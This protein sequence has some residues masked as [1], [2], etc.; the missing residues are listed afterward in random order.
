MSSA[1][2]TVPKYLRKISGYSF[3]RLV[4]AHEH[5]AELRELLLDRVVDDLGV[6]LGADAGEE[7]A[8][9]LGDAEPLERRLDLVGDV[10]PRLLLA[11]GRLAVVDDLVEVDPVEPVGPGRHRAL[12]EV[13]VRAEAVLEHPVRLVLEAADLLDR[14]ARQAALRLAQVDDVVV[15][16][17]L[18][19][20]VGDEVARRGHSALRRGRRGG[21]RTS[22]VVPFVI[23]SHIIGINARSVNDGRLTTHVRCPSLEVAVMTDAGTE[24]RTCPW[25]S[26]PA[27]DEARTCTS[28]GAALAQREYAGRGPDRGPD[29]RS[30]RSLAALGGTDP[31][32]RPEPAQAVSHVALSAAVIGGPAG[33]AMVGGVAAIAGAEYAAASRPGIRRPTSWTPSAAERGRAAGVEQIEAGRIRRRMRRRH[34]TRRRPVAGPA[35][36]ERS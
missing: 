8:L 3:E 24:P 30:I 5:D 32:G 6:V 12:Q 13:V 35:R 31:P 21:R 34:P 26:T 10:V 7:L 29:D 1:G 25:C 15:E 36:G 23:P 19:A 2:T 22:G 33:L 4:R 14:R 11:L 16:R 28:C 17:E 27:D 9:R 18:F 20:L